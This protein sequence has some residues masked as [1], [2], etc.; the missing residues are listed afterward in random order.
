M[1]RRERLPDGRHDAAPYVLGAL[2][3]DEEHAF[4]RHLERCEVCRDEVT[5]FAPVIEALPA[6]APAYRVPRALRRR[7]L[8][9]VRAEPKSAAARPDPKS[10]RSQAA[11]PRAGWLALG[12]AV[13]AAALVVQLGSPHRAERVIPATV[14]QAELRVAGDRGELIAALPALPTNRTYELWRVGPGG[15]PRP[16]TLF[17]ATSRGTADLG[18][19]GDLH[20]VTRLLVTVEPRGGS[21]VPT[22]RAVIQLPLRF[23]QSS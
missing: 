16:S 5:A 21:L 8:R 14:G 12:L 1:S 19:P 17:A 10:P 23:V 2:E 13:A 3:P 20:G 6:S 11:S 9:A 18:V 22:T 7:V 15:I 4:I